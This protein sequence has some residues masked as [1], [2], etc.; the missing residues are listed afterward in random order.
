MEEGDEIVQLKVMRRAARLAELI[1]HGSPEIIIRAEWDL[2]SRA[3]YRYRELAAR[4]EFEAA[5][6]WR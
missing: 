3:Y 4:K 1:Q 2:L 5:E 6:E